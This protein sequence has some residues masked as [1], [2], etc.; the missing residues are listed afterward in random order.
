[1]TEPSVGTGRR[2]HL[3]SQR[4]TPWLLGQGPRL[5]FLLSVQVSSHEITGAL[6]SACMHGGES[7]W[8]STPQHWETSSQ[9]QAGSASGHTKENGVANTGFI[10]KDREQPFSACLGGL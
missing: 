6:R 2:F 9:V 10:Q 1:M 5:S 7:G 8:V 4:N 3:I